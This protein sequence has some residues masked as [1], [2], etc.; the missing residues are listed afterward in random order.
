[1]NHS[2]T[3]GSTGRVSCRPSPTSDKDAENADFLLPT[4]HGSIPLT[5][6]YRIGLACPPTATPA[7]REAQ[8]GGDPTAAPKR[9]RPWRQALQARG[10]QEPGPR[11]IRPPREPSPSPSL[12]SCRQ[13]RGAASLRLS[14]ERKPP[15]KAVE[16][17]QEAERPL[18]T[19]PAAAAG[20][21]TRVPARGTL[22]MEWR[23]RGGGHGG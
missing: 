9:H 11:H 15:Q 7:P 10:P 12:R 23:G 16:R 13:A 21:H 17:D 1:M 5:V 2:P 19:R 4:N 3:M 18:R 6:K 20:M 8:W 22:S 14:G